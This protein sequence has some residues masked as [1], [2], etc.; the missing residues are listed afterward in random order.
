MASYTFNKP[1]VT[2]VVALDAYLRSNFPQYQDLSYTDP[3]LI[4]DT[5]AI[6]SAFDYNTL[7]NLVN[8]Y[9]DP[10]V[11]LQF[12]T[13]ITD[14]AVSDI[15]NSSTLTTIQK[16]IFSPFD[17]VDPTGVFNTFNVLLEISTPDI[18][19]FA[20]GSTAGS[21]GFTIFDYTNNGIIA[22]N[23]IDIS[24][25]LANWQTLA[26]TGSGP[27]SVSQIYTVDNL[28]GIVSPNDAIWF[29]QISVTNSNVNVRINSNQRIFY[30]VF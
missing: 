11:Y 3:Q 6:L 20:T 8:N 18:S 27:Q 25:I 26:Q 5:T 30:Q 7:T 29:L 10:V 4:V 23:T 14:N 24:S 12:E 13:K 28:R 21:I 16:L 19:N 9:T 22:Q 15:T 17:P 1:G 2:K